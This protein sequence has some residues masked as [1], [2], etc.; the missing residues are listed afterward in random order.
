MEP[1][2]VRLLGFVALAMFFENYDVSLLGALLK[3]IAE[4][5][6]L[7]K[8]G[9]GDFAGTIRLGTL[10]AFF[11]IPFAD[12]IGRRRLFLMSIVGISVGTF[13]TAFSQNA[14][15]FVACQ[16]VARSFI[17]TASA[18]AYVIVTEE[19]PAAHR[20]WGIGMLG[21]V[22]AV[23]FGASALLFAFIDVIPFGWRGMYALGI[24][25]LFFL[26]ILRRGIPETQRFQRQVAVEMEGLSSLRVLTGAFA[27][28]MEL[29]RRH[30]RRALAV[31]A[32]GGIST[33]GHATAFQLTGEYVLTVRGWEPWQYSAMFFLCGAI[34]II[35]SPLAGRLGDL[36]GRRAIG[37]A[38][39]GVFPFAAFAFYM[40]PGWL[41]PIGWVVMVFAV[42]ASSVVVRALSNE[43]FPTAQ[44]GTGGGL[45]SSVETLGAA[46]SLFAFS[47]LMGVLD[48]RQGLV[49][50]LISLLT[51]LSTAALLLFPE[52]RQRELESI[53]E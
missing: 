28:V 24:A 51:L 3:Y 47:F 42:M 25:P 15:Q 17:V 31:I 13:L 5:F 14:T 52:T 10:P 38:M 6:G 44:R 11:L 8:A 50:S 22:A 35:G 41:V 43:I 21:A 12:R 19:F 49:V 27:P 48:D 1:Q 53:S 45:L 32:L 29:V 18:I 37:A 23:G 4:D 2:H 40:G 33:A 30:P 7:S 39:L 20:G 9:L 36:Y 34:G 46:F 16:I 26:P